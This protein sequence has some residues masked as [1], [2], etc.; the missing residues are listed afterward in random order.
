MAGQPKITRFFPI[1]LVLWLLIVVARTGLNS[2]S[3]GNAAINAITTYTWSISFNAGLPYQPLTLNFPTQ[4]TI[5]PACACTIG[6]VTQS[7]NSTNNS[8]TI[9]ST[10][11]SASVSILCNNILNPSS[12][13]STSLFSYSNSNDGTVALNNVNQVQ[14]QG[15]TLASCPWSFSL[16]TGQPN[17]DLSITFTTI[18]NIPSGTNYFLIG[19]STTW[20]NDHSQ[21]LVPSTTTSLTCTYTLNN[22]GPLTANSCI[23]NLL[24]IQLQFTAATS[25]PLG[26]NVVVKVS[27]VNSPPTMQTTTSQDYFIYSADSS[28]NNIDGG[29]SCAISNVC[30]SNQTSATFTNTTMTVNANYG[31]PQLTFPITPFIITIQQ[32][33]TI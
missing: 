13:I 9:T 19:Y 12:A 8:I 1:W 14:F 3:V 21:G 5:L 2:V 7:I 22:T 26:T 18:N 30:V 25:I 31:N 17:S 33:D 28:Q 4:V 16:C 15:G 10:I 27:G 24:T 11:S 6:G 23:V 20:P 32:L 29:T